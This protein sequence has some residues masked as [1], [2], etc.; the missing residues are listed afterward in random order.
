MDFR[1]NETM[2]GIGIATLSS[3]EQRMVLTAL[4]DYL[5]ESPA[6]EMDLP[7]PNNFVS[8]FSFP[9]STYSREMLVSV[10]DLQNL[11][12]IIGNHQASSKL[13]A[14]RLGRVADFT[15]E[16]REAAVELEDATVRAA[17][18]EYLI[19]RDFE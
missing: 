9:Q 11:A 8:H 19:P 10:A 13:H 17:G 1:V 7:L 6:G 16:L 12:T 18:F 4:G 14:D 5:N 3:D 15:R 2:S